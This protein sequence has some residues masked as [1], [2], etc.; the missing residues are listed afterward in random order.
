MVSRP[1]GGGLPHLS[2]RHPSVLLLA[3]NRRPS[4]RSLHCSLPGLTAIAFAPFSVLARQHFLPCIP[5]TRA[6]DPIVFGVDIV[7]V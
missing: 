7:W 2:Q 1:R 5:D 6:I 3:Y 4:H